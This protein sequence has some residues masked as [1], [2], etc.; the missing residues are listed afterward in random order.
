MYKIYIL[1]SQYT[2]WYWYD[3]NNLKLVDKILPNPLEYKLFNNDVINTNNDLI[4][5]QIRT[6]KYIAGILLV[7]KSYGRNNKNKLQYRCV[8]NDPKIPIFLVPY[9]NKSLEFSK[10]IYNKFVLF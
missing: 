8:P 3:Q 5:S 4:F 9:E 6:D 10:T 1:N 2:E 7:E